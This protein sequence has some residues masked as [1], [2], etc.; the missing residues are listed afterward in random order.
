MTLAKILTTVLS[1]EGQVVLP[2][3]IRD[4]KNWGA[5]PSSTPAGVLLR[6]D[7]LFLVTKFT[8]VRGCLSRKGE[9][10]LSLDEIDAALR[11]PAKRRY[12]QD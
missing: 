9:K 1:T 3:A 7:R 10:S 5:A 2:E 11:A 8:E 4:E 12:A 6:S